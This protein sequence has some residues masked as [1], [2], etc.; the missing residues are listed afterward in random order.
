MES[1]KKPQL[2]QK[3]G[4]QKEAPKSEIKTYNVVIQTAV[5]IQGQNQGTMVVKLKGIPFGHYPSFEIVRTEVRNI[6][7]AV[8]AEISIL[9]ITPPLSDFQLQALYPEERPKQKPNLTS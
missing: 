6:T 1:N 4:E 9:S 8:D 3:E 7:Q 5:I 2:G